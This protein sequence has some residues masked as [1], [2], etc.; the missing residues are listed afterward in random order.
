MAQATYDDVTLILR[1]Y[2]M[3]REA[4][5]RAARGW[6]VKTCKPKTMAEFNELC[7]PGSE[8]N[9]YWRQVVTY[10][11]M[12]ASFVAAGV[13]NQE[14]FFQSGR[15]LLFVWIRTRPL[16]DELRKTFGDSTF[17]A[18]LEKVGKAYA[19]FLGPKIHDAYTAR[20]GG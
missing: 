10:W 4:T 16:I 13:L 3:R 12:A 15:E 8:A 9:A 7:P 2:E 18:N 14:L 6:F 20:V 11:D 17:L 5:M 19:E 1:L